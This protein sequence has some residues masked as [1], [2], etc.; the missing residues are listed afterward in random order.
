MYHNDIQWNPSIRTVWANLEFSRCDV[1][2]SCSDTFVGLVAV[3]TVVTTL[4]CCVDPTLMFASAAVLGNDL[5]PVQLRS[6]SNENT[7]LNQDTKH[8]PSSIEKCT[9]LPQM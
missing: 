7:S 8:G 2:G 3:T 5:G 4:D 6:L 9:K 1:R